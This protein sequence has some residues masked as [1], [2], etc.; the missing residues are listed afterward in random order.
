MVWAVCGCGLMLQVSLHQPAHWI[1]A[2]IVGP[3]HSADLPV[4][5]TARRGVC[6]RCSLIH[7]HTV[8][9]GMLLFHTVFIMGSIVGTCVAVS[10]MSHFVGCKETCV[11][12]PMMMMMMMMRGVM[13]WFAV[14]LVTLCGVGCVW[15]WM[16]AA[17]TS[18]ATSSL[19][20]GRHGWASSLG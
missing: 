17:G 5:S 3:A 1:P 9:C 18:T 11:H 19:D 4:S 16:G 13:E 14:G 20:P 7:Q 8:S 15:V 10:W 2:G 12:R 6:L